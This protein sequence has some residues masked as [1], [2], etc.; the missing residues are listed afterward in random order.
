MGGVPQIQLPFFPA[1]STPINRDLAF[2]QRDGRVCYF[3]GQLPVFAHDEKDIASFRLYTSQLI[4][5]GSASQSE[6]AS[7]F[8]VSSTTVKRYC[9]VLREEGT[10][11]FF[12]AA[13]P[14]SGHRLTPELLLKAQSCL[15][16]GWE[17]PAIGKELGVRAN[18]LHKAIWAG[19][20]KKKRLT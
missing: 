2:E 9:K 19:R 1:H 18:T 11:A 13:A 3:N 16:L 6:I 5:N 15:D 14:I 12:V 10:A 8:G 7:A 20:L 17:V 4:Q